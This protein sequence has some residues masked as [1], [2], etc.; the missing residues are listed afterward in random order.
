M[1]LGIFK[2]IVLLFGC[3]FNGY[4][5]QMT[6]SQMEQE[7]N[8]LKLQ[9]SQ[10]QG[11]INDLQQQLNATADLAALANSHAH[12]EPIAFAATLT[13]TIS[14]MPLHMHIPFDRVLTNIGGAYNKQT[15]HFTAPMFGL[16]VFFVVAT[17]TPTHAAS[18]TL[19]KNGTPQVFTLAHGNVNN[20]NV[21]DTSTM[22]VTL[23]LNDGDQVWA[24]N[25]GKFSDP[26]SLDGYNY[27]SFSG[28]MFHRM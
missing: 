15:G 9:M 5:A 10:M 18:L 3:F 1:E 21:F 20:G 26:E 13:R 27:S 12:N 6:S 8:T 22:T 2:S 17:N 28:F 4:V 16:Y 25:E 24:Q 23:L 19:M 7:I 11:T 14:N